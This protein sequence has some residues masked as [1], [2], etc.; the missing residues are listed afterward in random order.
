MTSGMA[1]ASPWDALMGPVHH[2]GYR[3]GALVTTLPVQERRTNRELP[4]CTT[5]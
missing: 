3:N 5:A 2:A 4:Q 1:P